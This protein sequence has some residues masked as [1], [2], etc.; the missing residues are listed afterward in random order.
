MNPKGSKSGSRGL[1][2]RLAGDTSGL[3]GQNG[4]SRRDAREA[5]LY[6]ISISLAGEAGFETVYHAVERVFQQSRRRY[7]FPR[8]PACA[9]RSA[10]KELRGG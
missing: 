10:D 7:V 6:L 5:L 1:N 8:Q 2:P 9:G 4:A 3:L